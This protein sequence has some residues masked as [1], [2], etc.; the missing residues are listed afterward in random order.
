MV[1]R[2]SLLVRL[3]CLCDHSKELMNKANIQPTDK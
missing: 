3:G 1:A 2:N